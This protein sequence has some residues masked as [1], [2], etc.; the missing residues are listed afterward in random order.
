MAYPKITVNTGLAL[1]L[2]SLF[3]I[4]ISPTLTEEKSAP[5]STSLFAVAAVVVPEFLGKSAAGIGNVSLDTS[6]ILTLSLDIFTS[7]ETYIIFLGGPNGSA[8]INSSEGCLL[9]V[10]SS[11]A[12]QTVATSY[13]NIKVQTVAGNDITFT[14]F[15]VGNYLP[16]QIMKLYTTGTTAATANNCIAIW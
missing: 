8:R 10:G 2:F 4:T 16:I 13:V 3:T 7:P 9:Y 11:E 1:L 5:T 15:P 6:T 14:G 12:T